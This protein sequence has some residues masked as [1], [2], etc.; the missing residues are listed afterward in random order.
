MQLSQGPAAKFGFRYD[1][2][3]SGFPADADILVDCYDSAAPAKEFFTFTLH[4]DGDGNA[5]T[6]SEC[7]S[8]DGPSHWVIVRDEYRSNLVDW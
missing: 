1:V 3:I 2:A 7:F 4:T 5:H 6:A 8:G